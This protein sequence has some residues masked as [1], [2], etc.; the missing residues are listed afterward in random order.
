M[1]VSTLIAEAEEYLTAAV[2]AQSH[3]DFATALRYRRK[4]AA[5]MIAAGADEPMR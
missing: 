2:Y 1:S 3:G 4:Y 5:L